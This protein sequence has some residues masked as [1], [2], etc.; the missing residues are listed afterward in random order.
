MMRKSIY[1]PQA[2]GES[3][4]GFNIVGHQSSV[5]IIMSHIA[6][7]S[8]HKSVSVNGLTEY[9][10]RVT[11]SARH[12]GRGEETCPLYILGANDHCSRR[13]LKP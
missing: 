10:K 4:N 8:V 7:R 12:S 1:R 9:L 2:K 11:G 13:A 5:L 6:Y 3:G